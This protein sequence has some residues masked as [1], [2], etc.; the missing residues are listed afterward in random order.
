MRMQ[1]TEFQLGK[2]MRR[3]YGFDEVALVPGD[4]T[5][6]PDMVDLSFEIGQYKFSVPD[7]AAAMDAIV[8]VT[9]AQ[10]LHE[11]GALAVM[12]LEGVQTRYERP[13]AVLAEIANT[14]DKEA[15]A[16]LQH[17]YSEPIK[18]HLIADRIRAIKKS[19]SV[20]AVSIT[21]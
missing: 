3:A 6:N 11:A 17:I 2:A 19:G 10:R 21:P 8:D 9:M 5:V 15:T 7:L 1:E 14:P 12:N 13:E 4:I 16:L 20:A 18:D